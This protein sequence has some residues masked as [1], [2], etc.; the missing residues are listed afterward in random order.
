[1]ASRFLASLVAAFGLLLS[2]PALAYAQD[3]THPPEPEACEGVCVAHEDMVQ[4]K[5]LLK[6]RHCLDTEEPRI[7]LDPINIVVDKEGR[8]FYSG[9][10]PKPYKIKVEWCNYA[11][12]ATG[13][14]KV[15][16]AVQEPP[17][18]GFRFRPKAYTGL[19]LAEPFRKDKTATDAIDAGLMIDPLYVK[20]FNLNF[21]VGFRS[22]GAGVGL[23]VFKNFG[24]YAG[25]ALAWDGL[26]HNPEAALWFAFW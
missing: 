19:L 2:E 5:E 24:I 13:K 11:M 15:L 21:H 6:E 26:S 18:Y 10:D 7:S 16:A 4:I 3:L 20:D 25:Y 17:S 1:M 8:V 9:N 22:V 14:V 23:D 12:E